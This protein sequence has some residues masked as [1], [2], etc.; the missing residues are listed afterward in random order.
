MNAGGRARRRELV[1]EAYNLQVKAG[2]MA[3]RMPF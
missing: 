1:D 3:R 2:M